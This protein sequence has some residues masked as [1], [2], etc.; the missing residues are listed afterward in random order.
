L[1]SLDTGICH[2][3]ACIHELDTGHPV[4]KPTVKGKITNTATAA[5]NEPDPNLANNTGTAVTK[6]MP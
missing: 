5:A 1:K 4:V 2:L 3:L 6:V